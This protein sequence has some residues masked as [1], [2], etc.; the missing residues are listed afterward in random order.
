M[1]IKS[2]HAIINVAIISFFIFSILGTTYLSQKNQATQT[3]A[4]ED[5]IA[6]QTQNLLGTFDLYNKASSA[7]DKKL[8][9]DDL[10]QFAAFRKDLIQQKLQSDPAAVLKNVI[11]P[12]T[13]AALP[14]EVAELI[15]KQ[16][17]L[18]GKLMVI[19][20][21]DLSFKTSHLEYS[22]IT[23]E[24]V[25]KLHFIKN[26][27]ESLSGSQVRIVGLVFD[28][29][30]VTESV[31]PSFSGTPLQF[32][33]QTISAPTQVASPQGEEKLAVILVNFAANS[34]QTTTPED[35]K[36]LMF[37]GANSIA[38][39]YRENSYGKVQYSGAAG[40][41]DIYG[42]YTINEYDGTTCEEKYY[43]W[44]QTANKRLAEAGVD[45]AQY[46]RRLYIFGGVSRGCGWGGVTAVGDTNAY[47]FGNPHFPYPIAHEMGHMLGVHHA[48]Y[49]D[50]GAKPVDEYSKCSNV[51]Y[52][53]G[54]DV[55][56]SQMHQF[57][58][59]HKV[60]AGWIGPERI[61]LIGSQGNYT[62]SILPLDRAPLNSGYQIVK[63]Y[64]AD[65]K[66][67]YYLSYRQS[68]G[69]FP[70][71]P[72]GITEGAS[73]HIWNDDKYTQ[74][75]FIDTTPS[76]AKI[77]EDAALSDGASFYDP[78]NKIT[79]RQ[80]SHDSASVRLE[81][82]YNSSA[83]SPSAPTASPTSIFYPSP[84]PTT[85]PTNTP[86]P[87]RKP[88]ATPTPTLIPT[89]IPTP[90]LIPTRIPT[91]TPRPTAIPTRIP[92]AIPT[93]TPRPT[94]TPT[95][96]PP[97]PTRVPPTPTLIPTVRPT[98]IPTPR[99]TDAPPTLLV[100]KVDNFS[101]FPN[102]IALTITAKDDLGRTTSFQKSTITDS[103]GF[104][105]VSLSGLSLNRSYNFYVKGDRQVS[106]VFSGLMTL[107]SGVNP[108][109]GFIDFGTLSAGDVNGDNQINA[110]DRDSVSALYGQN[111]NASYQKA[112]LNQDGRVDLYDI[113][114][115]N[116]NFGKRGD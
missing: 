14:P 59:P 23:E 47:I 9:L 10:F 71:I 77:L 82:L 3:K 38:N 41:G 115:V 50:C 68:I 113:S 39:Y 96:I 31:I 11:T 18:T 51:E 49:I 95:R 88:T 16:V 5:H 46:T 48:N 72:S 80:I 6:R 67:Y 43:L 109:V 1:S 61:L 86:T 13:R 89:R 102:N 63:I 106:K 40:R 24:K 65:T 97:T 12:E 44:G 73:V 101:N 52:A 32:G 58:G 90:T 105:S 8:Y 100:F 4:A 70:I 53:D 74:T 116:V 108:R 20:V 92:T 93:S 62:A 104:G 37:D 36:N 87:T 33:M 69:L 42:W 107:K 78:V 110:A 66:D 19:H 21:D 111:V 91:S 99:P 83:P 76:N 114:T 30:L 22:F 64:K 79:I 81:I 56:G 7:E 84:Y 25:Y 27:S 29:D 98:S 112:D 34:L 85:L 45:V 54:N 17:D 60:G 103:A 55:M 94:A 35:I 2:P 26:P 28:N 57:N 15:E 75:K